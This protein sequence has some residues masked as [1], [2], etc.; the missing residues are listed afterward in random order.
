MA[1]K[2]SR[3]LRGFVPQ[4]IPNQIVTKVYWLLSSFPVSSQTIRRNTEMNRK[5]LQDEQ[6]LL[7]SKD[8]GFIEEQSRWK[9]QRFGKKSVMSGV[10]CEVM[11]T[12][13]ALLDLGE[14]PD[15]VEQM[16]EL[17]GYYEKRGAALMGRF[18][19]AP[20]FVGK[21]FR[22]KGY[23]VHKSYSRK[24]EVINRLGER[25][26]SVIVSFYN[27]KKD[28]MYGVHTICI[29]KRDGKYYLHNAYIPQ[30]D[31]VG[32]ETLYDAFLHMSTEENA[33]LEIFG[34]CKKKD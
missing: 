3:M 30:K 31:K 22:K 29:S 23:E 20:H 18:G 12:Y 25:A 16:S 19:T 32:Y 28:L 6:E 11:A 27:N 24:R 2:L 10:G 1:R 34:I 14:Q 8:T 9:S 5:F 33:P 15:P 26:D 7:F 13:N 21:Y 4:Y 17:I